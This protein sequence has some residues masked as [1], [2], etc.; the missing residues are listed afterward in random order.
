MRLQ[1][2]GLVISVVCDIVQN[3]ITTLMHCVEL[4]RTEMFQI[5]IVGIILN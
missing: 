2:L 4:E 3:R 5:T 1:K